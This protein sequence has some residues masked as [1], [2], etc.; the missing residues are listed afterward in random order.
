V[1]QVVLQAS[2]KSAIQEGSGAEWQ[3]TVR[4]WRHG[5]GERH[6]LG[7]GGRAKPLAAVVDADSWMARAKVSPAPMVEP[8]VRS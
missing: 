6:S 2:S 7:V 8:L 5:P 3:P 1:N 4:R